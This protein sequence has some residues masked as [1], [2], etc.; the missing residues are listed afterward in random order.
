MEQHETNPHL[1]M[2]QF[3]DDELEQYTRRDNLRI[4]G[5]S[6][7]ETESEGELTAKIM[8]IAKEADV[9]LSA[10]NI[11][12]C[13]R[14]GAPKK[15]NPNPNES[16]TPTIP[17]KPRQVIV[18]FTHRKKKN[19]FYKNRFNLKGKD[20]CKGVFINEDL[21]TMRYKMMMCAR[22]APKVKGVISRDG[23]IICKMDDDTYIS[24]RNPDDLYDIGLEDVEYKDFGLSHL[25]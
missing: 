4:V 14:L 18:R 23:I 22:K 17:T 5:V 21:T 16:T 20:E 24:L 13:H 12:T 10:S 6:D 19:E 3:R 25:S 15:S 7:T 8:K 1:L 2:S 11:S 9:A